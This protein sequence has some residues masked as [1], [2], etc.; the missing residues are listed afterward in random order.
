MIPQDYITA[1]NWAAPWASQRQ[2]EQDLIISR[3]LVAIFSDPFLRGVQ[4]LRNHR[5]QAMRATPKINRLRRHQNLQLAAKTDH[6]ARR[7]AVST[8]DSVLASTPV[9]TRTSAP[10]VSISI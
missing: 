8:T 10:N 9:G 5:D 2:V 6:E 7:S 1:W 4:R 3:A